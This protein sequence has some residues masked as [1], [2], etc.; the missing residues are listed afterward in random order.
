MIYSV[1]FAALLAF[2]G[3]LIFISGKKITQCKKYE[4]E[5]RSDGGVVSFPSFEES[6]KFRRRKKGAE[7]QQ[8]AGYVICIFAVFALALALNSHS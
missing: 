2:G 1:L 7:G 5:N 4:F 6:E 8:S 3:F